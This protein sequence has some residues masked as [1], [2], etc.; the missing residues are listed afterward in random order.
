VANNLNV[1][2]DTLLVAN[3]SKVFAYS[4]QTQSLYQLGIASGGTV[5]IGGA[6][7]GGAPTTF[8]SGV[9][10]SNACHHQWKA[11]RV[12]G[13]GLLVAICRI[14]RRPRWTEAIYCRPPNCW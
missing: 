10:V 3:S 5:A 4:S 2:F 14:R 1:V 8:V 6:T 12:G 7:I 9:A 13:E 11:L